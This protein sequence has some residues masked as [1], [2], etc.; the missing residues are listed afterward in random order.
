M[1]GYL[2]LVAGA[3]VLIGTIDLDGS[4]SEVGRTIL[5]GA[6][7][8][9]KSLS[10]SLSG[11][12]ALRFAQEGP[13]S[14][15]QQAPIL[16][17]A[18]TLLSKDSQL[19]HE[20]LG[21][22]SSVSSQQGVLQ[23]VARVEPA[24]TQP[25]HPLVAAFQELASDLCKRIDSVISH[26]ADSVDPSLSAI[27]NEHPSAAR[28]L[29]MG[30]TELPVSSADAQEVEQLADLAQNLVRAAELRLTNRHVCLV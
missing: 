22:H 16:H 23:P 4:M 26:G 25:P 14:M 5:R 2:A 3:L 29:L 9:G 21:K 11:A 30:G 8:S 7:E 15:Q 13:T 27:I 19:S 28:T 17:K 24:Q 18:A 20:V 6:T 1:K 10:D 12:R